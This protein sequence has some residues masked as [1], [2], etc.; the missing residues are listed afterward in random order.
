MSVT[1]D[2]GGSFPAENILGISANP[3]V[4]PELPPAA[5]DLT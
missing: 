3:Q 2:P 5:G 4:T 1:G